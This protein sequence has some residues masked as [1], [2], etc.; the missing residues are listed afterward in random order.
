MTDVRPQLKSGTP[1]S[2]QTLIV[3]PSATGEF[4]PGDQVEEFRIL[5]RLGRGA[6][7]AVYL[8]RQMTARRLVAMKVGPREDHGELIHLAQ[9]DHPSVVRLYDRRRI[10]K[11]DLQ[12]LYLEYVA[13]GSLQSAIELMTADGGRPSGKGLLAAIDQALIEAGQTVPERSEL[14]KQIRSRPWPETVAWFGIQL[15]E[16]LGAAHRRGI[17]HL[18]IKP[19]NVLIASDGLPKL[20]DFNI[21]VAT[22]ESAMGGRGPEGRG[23]IEYM[24]PEQI[25]AILGQNPRAGSGAPHQIDRRSD[26]YALALLLWKMLHG[27]P[28]WGDQA[29]AADPT[30]STFVPSNPLHQLEAARD[31][32]D[33]VAEPSIASPQKRGSLGNLL[34]R[35]L[36]T[37]PDDRPQT[38]KEFALRL[39]LVLHPIA[40]KIIAPKET[41][42]RSFLRRLPPA[43][44][45]ASLILIPNIAA[46]VF[47]FY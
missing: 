19:A 1:D 44:V 41:G 12:F 11:T 9:I 6:F 35:A 47:N 30:A 8:A 46:G 40:E 10:E 37:D 21:S 42:F 17:L 31:H 4:Q 33:R 43:V 26:L 23:T 3:A 22:E 20:T 16:G 27:T 38:A 32:R 15:A 2:D 25:D 13:G 18:D 34:L 45:S 36:S 29:P 14:R 7:A 24:S 5:Q 28:P 39:R